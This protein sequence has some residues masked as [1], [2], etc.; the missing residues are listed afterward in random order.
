MRD[1]IHGLNQANELLEEMSFVEAIYTVNKVSQEFLVRPIGIFQLCDYVGLDVCQFIMKV[2]KPRL[3]EDNLHSE[4]LDKMVEMGVK[5][6]Q[7]ADGSQKDG[8]LKYEKGRPGAV[9]SIKENKYIPFAQFQS[10]IDE[11]LGGFPSTHVAWKKMLGIK[12]R[13]PLL[14]NYFNDLKTMDTLG[15]DLARKYMKK[16]KEIGELLVNKGIAITPKDVNSV[17]EMGFF[18]VYG[19]INDYV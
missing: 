8:F 16:S 11:K 12:D 15:A 13:H 2:M 3:A 18:H 5:G 17:L 1:I 14:S 9:F 6:G 19:P 4:L 10:K 7:Y